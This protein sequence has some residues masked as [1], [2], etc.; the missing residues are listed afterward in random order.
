MAAAIKG[1]KTK[2]PM[3]ASK[4]SR[5]TKETDIQ[6]E[7][8]L[9][10]S[11]KSQISTSIAFLDHMLTLLS[12]HGLFD[13]RISA[14]GDTEVDFHHTVEDIGICLG[15]AIREA[16]GEKIALFRYGSAVIPMD[17]SLAEVHV[18][19]SGRPTL[20]YQVPFSRRKIGHFDTELIQEFLQALV[21]QGGMTLHA[22]VLY[23]RNGHHM[24][25]ALFKAL[26]WALRRAVGI[27]PRR[28]GVPSTKGKL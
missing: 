10:G 17:E 3:R 18:D 25:E 2:S 23:G 12:V 19:L 14:R 15:K 4:V 1:M 26:G 21:N 24:V 16:L 22:R 28:P 7:L 11:G 27:D 13:L 5:K 9:D 6:I 20:V 8:N